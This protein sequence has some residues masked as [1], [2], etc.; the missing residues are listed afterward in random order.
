METSF[1]GTFFPPSTCCW[2]I[3]NSNDM[4]FPLYDLPNTKFT[5][6]GLKCENLD[7]SNDD[8]SYGGVDDFYYK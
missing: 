8:N 1:N 2:G 5:W 6:N 7:N 4:N 3:S